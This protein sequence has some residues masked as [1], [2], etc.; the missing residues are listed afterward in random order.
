MIDGTLLLLIVNEM[1]LVW[2]FYDLVNPSPIC[3]KEIL[4]YANKTYSAFDK[5][6]MLQF[7]LNNQQLHHIYRTL[8]VCI[9]IRLETLLGRSLDVKNLTKLSFP[10]RNQ[11]ITG[12]FEA[13]LALLTNSWHTW[14]IWRV[15]LPTTITP[16]NIAIPALNIAGN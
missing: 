6:I 16:N 8:E 7:G 3:W 13:I 14:F 5:R 11:I 1:I 12:L 4:Q 9:E 10:F 15:R 2:I